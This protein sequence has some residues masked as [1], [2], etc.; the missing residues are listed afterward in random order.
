MKHWKIKL[1]ILVSVISLA[2]VMMLVTGINIVKDLQLK[3]AQINV[4]IDEV[5]NLKGGN[6][7]EK[8]QVK[9]EK[10]HL[11]PLSKEITK[12][13]EKISTTQVTTPPVVTPPL[14]NDMTSYLLVGQHSRLT[15]SIIVATLNNASKEVTLISIPRDF[16]IE[17]RKINEFY[18]FFGIQKLADEVEIITGIKIN[19]FIIVDMKAFT[20]YIDAIG[21]IDIDV[22]KG[23]Y[24]YKYP[25]N[26]IEY[27]TFS[28]GA[29]MHHMDGTTALKY[30][31]SR[32]STS[33]FDRSRRQ[34][35]IISAV[36][37]RLKTGG[38][39]DILAN[40][41]NNLSKN[42][43]T[44]ISFIEAMALASQTADYTIKTN[45]MIESSN[46]LFSTYNKQGQWILLPKTG[47][48][49]DIQKQ[50][51]AWIAE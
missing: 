11:T 36:K 4:L 34:Q 50:V 45:H 42:I 28:I 10:I 2:T 23:I 26:N 48:Y 7:K 43:E 41:Y 3:Q 49:E 16:A 25:K 35:Q 29:G 24:D 30:A 39:Y 44:N 8:K 31:R 27:E 20:Q 1:G 14:V 37:E 15:D 5:G 40:L 22:E 32:K 21:G 12:E 17:G 19:N 46:L 6:E 13:D 18:E 51:Q 9:K 33:D 38:F 47:N